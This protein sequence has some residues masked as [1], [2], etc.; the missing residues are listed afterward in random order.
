MSRRVNVEVPE[1]LFRRFVD[2]L[3]SQGLHVIEYIKGGGQRYRISDQ[4]PAYPLRLL[5]KGEPGYVP[6]F[7]AKVGA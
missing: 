4:P 7:L 5:P 1:D 2:G 6:A 3:D